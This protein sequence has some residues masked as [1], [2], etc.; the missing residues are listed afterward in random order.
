MAAVQL[1]QPHAHTDNG[2]VLS[3][4]QQQEE[5]EVGGS[6]TGVGK[7]ESDALMQRVQHMQHLMVSEQVQ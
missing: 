6:R 1:P 2:H 5:E 7:R 4:P 3:L